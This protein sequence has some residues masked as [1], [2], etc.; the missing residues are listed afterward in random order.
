MSDLDSTESWEDFGEKSIDYNPLFE[1]TVDFETRDDA[2]NWAQKIAFENGFAL[3]KANNGA[4]NRHG[5]PKESDDLEKPRRSQKCSCKFRIRAVQ[6]FVPKNDKETIVWNIVTSEGAGLHNHNAAVYKDGD[7]HFAGLDAE[8]KAYVRQQTLAG[9]LPRDIK[10]CLHL[11]T[12]EKPEPSSTQVYNETRKIRKEVMG[13]RNTA[14]QMLALAVEA[15][16]V[17]FYEIDSESKELTHIFMAHPKAIKLFRAY[18]YVVLMDSTYKT[19]IYKNPLIEMVGV[20]PTGSSFLIAC[21]MI[22]TES[23]VNYKWLLRKLDA[24]LDVAGVASPAVFVTD[25]ELGLISALE[26]VFPR[27]EHLL[28][29]WHVNKAINAKAFTSF[30]TESIRKYV[31]SNE[32]DGWFKVINSVTEESFQRAWQCFQLL[33]ERLESVVPSA[34][35]WHM[36]EE[37]PI[38]SLCIILAGNPDHVL[39]PAVRDEVVS[40]EALN[41]NMWEFRR[42]P[43]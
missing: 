4:K 16:Y 7:R 17:H 21:S 1:T 10:N 2:F 6:N 38:G 28:C 41:E 11:R 19:N 14:Q 35:V 40:D 43:Q 20:T 39:T 34:T 32:E 31:I 36:L 9:V 3:V 25:R 15:K 24:I 37:P 26:Q 12:P 29:R 18:P 22:P 30:R 5:K 27:A 8:E 13:E 23:D 42:K 33:I